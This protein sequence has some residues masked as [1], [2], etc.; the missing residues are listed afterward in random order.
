[1]VQWLRFCASTDEGADPIPGWRTKIP[2]AMGHSQ[3]KI[4]FKHSVKKEA[5][6]KIK[7]IR[8]KQGENGS[9]LAEQ[10]AWVKVVIVCM[11]SIQ[12]VSFWHRTQSACPLRGR[13]QIVLQSA[14]H[15]SECWGCEISL[16]ACPVRRSC[17][18]DTSIVILLVHIYN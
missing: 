1:M 14:Q 17:H 8:H 15:I 7:F 11:Q 10:L 6:R 2:H 18:A 12:Y 3:K 5:N 13:S 9:V 16:R 4:F